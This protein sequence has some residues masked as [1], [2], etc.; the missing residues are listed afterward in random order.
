MGG[1]NLRAIPVFVSAREEEGIARE[2]FP[3]LAF[4][5]ASTI[6]WPERREQNWQRLSLLIVKKLPERPEFRQRISGRLYVWF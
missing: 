2:L 1:R 4:A 5:R 3:R 6:R